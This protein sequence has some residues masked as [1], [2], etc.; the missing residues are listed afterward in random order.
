MPITKPYPLTIRQFSDGEYSEGGRWQY[1]RHIDYSHK[2]SNYIRSYLLIQDDL[3]DLFK[4]VEPSDDSLKTYSFRIQELF[5]RT[6]IE[7]EANFKAIFS[8]NTYTP[9]GRL[10]IEDYYLINTSHYLS[11]YMVKLPYWSGDQ[12]TAMR[13]PFRAWGEPKNVCKP[14]NLPW[15]QDY[16]AVK[17]DRA[18]SLHLANL[19]NLIDAYCGLVAVITSQYLFEGFSPAPEYLALNS[20]WNDGFE[21][22]IGDY[23]RVRIP[24]H[25]PEDERYNFNW[26]ELGKSEAP[27]Q[28]FDYDAV[29]EMNK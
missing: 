17:H 1:I 28:K 23:F 22:A 15:Y 8:M 9:K 29:K 14:W 10:S 27:F 7:I 18:N 6:C 20:G 11:S 21:S 25:V 13:Q 5:I 2:P 4:Y 24:Q 16:N 3:I 26:D 19:E 12:I